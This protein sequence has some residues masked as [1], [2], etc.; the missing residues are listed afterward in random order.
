MGFERETFYYSGQGVVM[1]GEYDETTGVLLGLKALGNC[2]SLEITVDVTTNEH[3]E[4]QT[5][6]R[7]TDLRKEK[8]LTAGVKL[9]CQ[10]FS[11]DV[12]ALFTRGTL[13]E[14][15]SGNVT[16]Y[17]M[18]YHKGMI[19]PLPHLAV[20]AV[21]VKKGAEELVPYADDETAYD[22]RLNA[23]A[24]SIM[25]AD[26]PVTAGL[27]NGDGLVVAYTYASQALVDS[28]TKASVSRLLR[29]E[30]LNT[31]DGNKPVVV[32]VFKAQFDPAKVLTLISDEDVQSFELEG[33]ALADMTRLSGSKYFRERLL[34]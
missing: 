26:T 20:S 8:E 14:I 28:L 17:A 32:E 23:A 19:M 24:G 7:A 27:V 5:G 10:N 1:V 18:A 33:S 2:P 29:F 6:Q 11:R 30:G 31:A 12:L 9:T 4:S 13:T 25:F 3:K 16:D 15:E 21:T 22:Y 34:R